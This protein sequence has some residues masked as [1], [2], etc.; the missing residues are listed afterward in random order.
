MSESAQAIDPARIFTPQERLE[1]A[2]WAFLIALAH[3]TADPEFASEGPPRRAA[4]ALLSV[5]REQA[6]KG[7]CGER[8]Y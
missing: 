4:K 2:R 8:L 7:P 5:L 6:W 1:S 3:Q